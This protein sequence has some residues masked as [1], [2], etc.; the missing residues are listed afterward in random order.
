M[1]ILALSLIVLPLLLLLGQYTSELL[2]VD[3]CLDAGMVYDYVN[4][5]CRSDLDRLP[6]ISY[7]ERS[8]HLLVVV[9]VSF[10]AGFFVLIATRK[11]KV[12]SAF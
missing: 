3:S 2:A 11:Q 8:W 7:L 9:A 4:D 1:R 5:I 10:G 12:S 6:Y